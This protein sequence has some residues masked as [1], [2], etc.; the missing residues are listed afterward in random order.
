MTGVIAFNCDNC[1]K[2]GL[3]VSAAGIVYCPYCR[4]SYGEQPFKEI[5]SALSKFSK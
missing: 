5:K 2:S 1:K 4:F 3:E